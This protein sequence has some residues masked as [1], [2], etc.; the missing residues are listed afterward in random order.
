MSFD[1]LG[2][3]F[4]SGRWFCLCAEFYS[5]NGTYISCT[6]VRRP[7]KSGGL[8]YS[9]LVLVNESNHIETHPALKICG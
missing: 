9:L 4:I 7:T 1:G 5:L 8:L 3:C 6:M 2:L